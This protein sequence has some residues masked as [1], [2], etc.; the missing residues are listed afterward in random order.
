MIDKEFNSIIELLKYFPDED[1][2]IKHLEK[3]RWA[4]GI[5]S[6]FNILSRVYKCK[7]GYKCKE[8]GKYFN[9]KTGTIFENTQLE[10]QK[11]FLAIWLITCGKKGITSVQLAKDIGCT[12]KTAW[13]MAH[14]IRECFGI[15]NN[16]K[17]DGN[18]EIDETFIGGKNKNRH[19]KKR[20]RSINGRLGIKK[21]PVLG[22]VQRGGK[23]I[24]K[25]IPNTSAKVL[26]PSIVNN[27]K[28][29]TTIYTD[30]WKG[31]NAVKF[32]YDHKIVTHS[33][34]NYV[35]G[36]AHTNTIEGFWSL[37]KRG[38]IGVYHH[39]SKKH[40]QKYLDEFVFRYNTRQLSQCER[41]NLTLYN[42]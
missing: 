31:Y 30:E 14:K 13:N 7:S 1:S 33:H 36:I 20:H 32:N 29:F 4:R 8:T 3:I 22:M 16:H 42:I 35:N 18:V 19:Y 25:V 37:L 39:T 2:C 11:W 6:P 38:L 23:L 17:L 9:V 40:L 10:L 34:G 26:I 12:Q 15:E 28:Y 41:F 27:V 5:T 24:A 21:I